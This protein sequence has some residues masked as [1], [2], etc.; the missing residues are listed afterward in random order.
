MN[1]LSYPLKH[2]E[3]EVVLPIIGNKLTNGSF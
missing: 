2:A 1:L 3:E